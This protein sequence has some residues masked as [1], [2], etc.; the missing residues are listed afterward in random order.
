[1]SASL[2]RIKLH[3]D[4]IDFSSL[5]A[6]AALSAISAVWEDI[7]PDPTTSYAEYTSTSSTSGGTSRRRHLNRFLPRSYLG[8]KPSLD[9]FLAGGSRIDVHSA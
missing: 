7:S 2:T 1:M 3:P 8:A 6:T 9:T 5:N 4:N